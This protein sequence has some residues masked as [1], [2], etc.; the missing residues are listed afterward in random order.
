MIFSETAE[1]IWLKFCTETE[2]C[3]GHCVQDFWSPQDTRHGSQ[4][5]T[6]GDILGHLAFWLSLLLI[7]SF[8]VLVA[9]DK[10]PINEHDD[11]DDDDDH[12]DQRRRPKLNLNAKLRTFGLSPKLR[13][14]NFTEDRLINYSLV[15]G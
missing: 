3:S 15:T 4:K 13:L 5:C 11:D 14:T 1:L 10:L 7:F 8:I 6:M 9:F 12:D 2:V